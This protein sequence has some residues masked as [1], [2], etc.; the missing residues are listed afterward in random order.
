MTSNVKSILMELIRWKCKRKAFS[1]VWKMNIFL[2]YLCGESTMIIRGS[3]VVC[4]F[5]M[6]GVAWSKNKGAFFIVIFWL[7]VGG[8]LVHAPWEKTFWCSRNVIARL[9]LSAAVGCD[10]LA[11]WYDHCLRGWGWGGDLCRKLLNC[12]FEM[13]F[14]Q[15]RR[16]VG[17]CC[18]NI[19]CESLG[20]LGARV[21]RHIHVG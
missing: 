6:R 13:I 4:A 5:H 12:I 3:G 14:E 11:T 21:S 10:W 18:G 8:G 15:D 17:I 16:I 2:D 9:W 19:N 7:F 20:G 1:D